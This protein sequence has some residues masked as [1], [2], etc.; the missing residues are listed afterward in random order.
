MTAE[1]KL[2]KLVVRFLMFNL[3]DIPETPSHPLSNAVGSPDK[4]TQPL[5]STVGRSGQYYSTVAKAVSGC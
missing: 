5:Q 1:R 4:A 2:F 3:T